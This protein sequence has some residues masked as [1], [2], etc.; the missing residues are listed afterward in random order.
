MFES[1]LDQICKPSPNYRLV[2]NP[3]L[4]ISADKFIGLENTEPRPTLPRVTVIKF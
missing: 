1:Q 4:I 3:H 2:N